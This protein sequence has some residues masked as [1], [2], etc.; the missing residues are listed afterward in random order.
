[1]NASNLQHAAFA[2]ALQVIL[3]LS[4]GAWV[5]AGV[6]PCMFFL[7][8]EVAQREYHL[9]GGASVKTLKPWAGFDLLR[10]SRDQ[11][12]DLGAPAIA[13]AVVA[14]AGPAVLARL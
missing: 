6:V 11:L 2:V 1:M 12:G 8:R 10:W 5:W 3:G 13:C 7:G 14:W 4:T 9:T